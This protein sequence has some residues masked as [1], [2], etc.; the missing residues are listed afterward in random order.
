MGERSRP[1]LVGL[2]SAAVLLSYVDRGTLPLAGPLIT[3]EFGLSATA[4]GV[5]IS[6]FFWVYA[7]AQ[8]L[9]GWMVDRY[10]AYTLFGAG[11]ALWGVA[12]ALTGLAGGLVSLIALRLM[13]GLGQS[14]L[15]PGSSKLIAQHCTPD[16]RG[17]ANGWVMAGLAVGQ[18]TGALV[19]GLIMAAYGWRVMCLVLGLVT[20]VWLIPWRLVRWADEPVAPPVPGQRQVSF[21]EILSKPALWSSAVAHF[22][23]NYGFYFLISWLPL[24]LVKERGVSIALM[25]V[26]TGMTFAVQALSSIGF[27]WASDRLIRDGHDEATVRKLFMVVPNLAKAAAILA[28][29]LVSSP[30]AVG[31]WLFV[32]ALTLGA[33]SVQNF[34]IPQTFA[35]PAA[36][37]RWVGVQ[38]FGGNCAGIIGPVVTGMLIDATGNYSAAFM[39][40]AAITLASALFWG[41]L[42]PRIAPIAWRSA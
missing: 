13:L 2:L 28:I 40:A 39:L 3:G 22:C 17:S 6:A 24:Y 36:A 21:G 18:A 35:G 32:V 27:G 25:A 8:L 23:G 1:L 33:T 30:M 9:C 15:F 29:A 20:L 16:Q 14:F 19:G 34:A 7:P 41:P 31:F 11:L 37:G 5:A 12:T 38:N 4:F 42:L 26:L 10:S